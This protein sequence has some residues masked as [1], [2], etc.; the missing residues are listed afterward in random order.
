MIPAEKNHIDIL[1]WESRD[2]FI[3]LNKDNSD[4]LSGAMGLLGG[5]CLGRDY[6][7]HH[8]FC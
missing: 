5:S 4:F 7:F 8:R 3:G 2:G 1:K 6:Y